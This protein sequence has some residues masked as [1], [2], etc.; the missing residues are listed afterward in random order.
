M[1]YEIRDP[2][3]ERLKRAARIESGA[4]SIVDAF[5][6]LPNLIP[7][8]LAEDSK[9]NAELIDILSDIIRNGC[10]DAVKNEVSS[11]TNQVESATGDGVEL[12]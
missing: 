12:D 8:R 6:D 4:A 9:W 5:C 7:R 11:N 1:E 10:K 3:A 2:W